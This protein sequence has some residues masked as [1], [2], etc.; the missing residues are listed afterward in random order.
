MAAGAH[1][2]CIQ[3]VL[4][5]TVSYSNTVQVCVYC[6]R[7]ILYCEMDYSNRLFIQYEYNTGTVPMHTCTGVGELN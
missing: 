6:V 2:Y 4:Y 5:H 7:I 1:M 3:Y